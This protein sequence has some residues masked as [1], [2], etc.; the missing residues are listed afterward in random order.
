M[1]IQEV[2]KEIQR[3]ATDWNIFSFYSRCYLWGL[4][5]THTTFFSYFHSSPFSF[6]STPFPPEVPPWE[7]NRRHSLLCCIAFVRGLRETARKT[8]ADTVSHLRASETR[9]Q[10]VSLTPPRASLKP[11]LLHSIVFHML[12]TESVSVSSPCEHDLSLSVSMR[13]PRTGSHPSK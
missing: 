6:S 12:L 4:I 9:S 7:Y 13:G 1:H 8:C 10:C 5:H 11:S 3:N 2:P